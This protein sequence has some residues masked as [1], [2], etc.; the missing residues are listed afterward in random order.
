[1]MLLH[2][3]V[4]D[5]MYYNIYKQKFSFYQLNQIKYILYNLF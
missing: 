3:L 1:M 2:L 4:Y 5:Y